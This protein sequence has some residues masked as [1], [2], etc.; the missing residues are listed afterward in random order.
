MILQLVFICLKS[1]I[2]T[3]EQCVKFVQR[4]RSGVFIVNLEQISHIFQVFP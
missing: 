3:H 1:T 2:K 4:R